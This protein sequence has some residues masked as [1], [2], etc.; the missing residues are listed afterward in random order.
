M[1]DAARVVWMHNFYWLAFTFLSVSAVKFCHAVALGNVKPFYG[2][3]PIDSHG[4]DV[5]HMAVF[6][7]LHDSHQDILSGQS[8]V[9][10]CVVYGF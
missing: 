7:V 4:S 3:I 6:F 10:V 9:L 5:D 8:V 1:V 2:S